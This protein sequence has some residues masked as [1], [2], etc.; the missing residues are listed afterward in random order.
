MARMYP[1]NADRL[2]RLQ[3][4]DRAVDELTRIFQEEIL[5]Q[6]DDMDLNGLLVDSQVIEG[7]R[8]ELMDE[9]LSQGGPDLE[10]Y[11]QAV[12]RAIIRV[13]GIRQTSH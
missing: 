10:V 8:Q 12:N 1:I 11:Q 6:L 4:K 3:D 13:Q 7:F 5:E 9:L 2:L